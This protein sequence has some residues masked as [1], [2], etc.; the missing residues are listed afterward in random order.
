MPTRSRIETIGLVISTGV[1]IV[2]LSVVEL[3]CGGMGR[4]IHGL[5]F[6][7]IRRC[8]FR[9]RRDACGDVRG[10]PRAILNQA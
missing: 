5:G 4:G 10:A 2:R 8:A 6:R 7:I 9:V 1:E 3:V